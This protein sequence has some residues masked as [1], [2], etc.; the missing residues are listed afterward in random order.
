[1]LNMTLSI[2]ITYTIKMRMVYNL[3]VICKSH[4]LNTGEHVPIFSNFENVE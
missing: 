1:M 4:F 3:D 2:S